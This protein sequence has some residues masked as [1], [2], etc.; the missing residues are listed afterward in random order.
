MVDNGAYGPT[1]S[2]ELSSPDGGGPPLTENIYG[3]DCGYRIAAG[4][5]LLTRGSAVTNGPTIWRAFAPGRWTDVR[6]L[7]APDG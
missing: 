4:G 2:V 7:I 3:D 6:A 1:I 5:V